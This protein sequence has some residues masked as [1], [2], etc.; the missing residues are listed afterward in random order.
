MTNRYRDAEEREPFIT[1][2]RFL[3]LD[4]KGLIDRRLHGA[5]LKDTLPV[6]NGGYLILRIFAD[7]PGAWFMH[8]H[9]AVHAEVGM[10]MTLKVTNAQGHLP[11][12]P[13][14]FPRCGPWPKARHHVDVSKNVDVRGDQNDVRIDASSGEG[15]AW[16]VPVLVASVCVNGLMVLVGFFYCVRKRR[17]AN[18][19]QEVGYQPM[20]MSAAQVYNGSENEDSVLLTH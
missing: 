17:G 18:L 5:P 7:N 16:A 12:P 8:C 6:P 13:P 2:E 11:A 15:A 20:Q 3:E 14:N 9:I 10:S 1:K 19:Y 4:R